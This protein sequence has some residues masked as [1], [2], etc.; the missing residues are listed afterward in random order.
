MVHLVDDLQAQAAQA[1]ER[2][3]QA[4]IAARHTHARA[5]LMRHMLA[6]ARKVKDRPRAEA[7]ETVVSEWLGAWHLERTQWP[8]LARE[9]E[10]LTEVFYDYVHD[11]S[12]AND[13]R[14][15]RSCDI[16]D[17]AFA[18]AE[19]T[20]SDQMAWRSQCAHGWWEL[21]SPTPVDLPGRKQRSAV[22]TYVAGAAF[23]NTGCADFCT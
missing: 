14:L 11:M 22:P 6:T 21:V 18:R 13:A 7:V 19:T 1:V 2:M 5:E 17:T 10:A 8:H 23:W 16:L 4:A 12:D 15:R 3:Q 9:M 20:I